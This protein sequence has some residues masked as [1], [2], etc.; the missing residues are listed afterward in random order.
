VTTYRSEVICSIFNNI[1]FDRKAVPVKSTTD[2][3]TVHIIRST[4]SATTAKK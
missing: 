4:T 2:L 3:L 1:D